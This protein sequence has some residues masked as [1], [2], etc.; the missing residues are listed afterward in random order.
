MY[1]NLEELADHN[2]YHNALK[3]FGLKEL[4]LTLDDLNTRRAD[5]LKAAL[6]KYLK[7]PKDLNTNKVNEWRAKF[8]QLNENY[9]LLKSYICNRF[10][11][12]RQL[13]NSNLKF[14]AKGIFHF[15]L[16]NLYFMNFIYLLL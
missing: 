11:S 14:N 6:M 16:V 3:Y 1:I 8:N 13:K 10:E 5:F 7:K 2:Q 15:I 12:N 9:E 4:S